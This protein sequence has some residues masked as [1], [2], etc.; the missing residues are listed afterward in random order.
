M[1]GGHR[2]GVREAERRPSDVVQLGHD[3]DNCGIGKGVKGKREGNKEL[4]LIGFVKLIE[5]PKDGEISAIFPVLIV[6]PGTRANTENWG[7]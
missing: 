3:K 5:S 2:T 4:Q 6:N 7:S 1:P